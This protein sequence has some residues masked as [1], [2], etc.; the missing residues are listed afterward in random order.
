MNQQEDSMIDLRSDTVT[1]PSEPMR[2]AMYEAEVGDDVYG[3]DPTINTLEIYASEIVG[4]KAGIFLPSGSMG[5]LIALM[6]QASPGSEVLAHKN[7]HIFHFELGS[8]AAFA[9][10][11]PIAMEGEAGTFTAEEIEK[12]IRPDIYYMSKSALISL[13]NTHNLEGGRIWSQDQ[14]KAVHQIAR[15]HKLPVHMDGARLFNAAVASDTSA[16]KIAS[17]TDTITFCLSKGLGAPVGSIL[18]GSREFI[19]EARVLRKRLG[20]GMRQAG[21]LAAAGLYALRNN[22]DRLKEDHEHARQIALSIENS[23]WADIDVSSVET[24]IGYFTLRNMTAQ[25]ACEKLKQ[26]GLLMSPLGE[27]TIRFVTHLDVNESDVKTCCSII[28]A[29]G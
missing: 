9:G 15:K 16:K 22:R 19:Q 4:K 7:S 27:G 5:N 2:K 18:C 29:F 11:M 23:S 3:E 1:K 12:K 10:L 25:K 26:K 14:L 6:A 13:E 21:I 8:M 28:E 17:F 24:N 20:G